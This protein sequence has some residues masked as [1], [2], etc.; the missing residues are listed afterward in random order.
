MSNDFWERGYCLIE[1]CLDRSKLDLANA[2]L[3]HAMEHFPMRERNAG[4]VFKAR[5]EYSPAIGEMLLRYC[6]PVFE[7]A[8]GRKLLES[9]A[10]WRVYSEGA[11]LKPHTDRVGCEISA[12]ITIDRDPIDLD[13]PI[14]VKD[15][16]DNERAV[17]LKPGT[18]LLYQGHKV[19]H[20][21]LPFTGFS[22]KQLLFHYVLADGEFAE[23]T[24]DGRGVDPVED[25]YAGG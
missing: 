19:P 14:M 3:S 8:V 16:Q 4:C 24:F 20:W 1:D 10:Y 12:T 7:E 2:S 25:I 9:F 11:E 5:D 23:R 18:A 13:W 6:Q 17:S 21:R 15:I 22:Q